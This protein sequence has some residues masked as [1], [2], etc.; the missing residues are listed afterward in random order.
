MGKV[1][2]AATSD[3][4][5]AVARNSLRTRL[6]T[7]ASF[8]GDQ[9]RVKISRRSEARNRPGTVSTNGMEASTRPL[10][11]SQATITRLR[12]HRSTRTPAAGAKKKPGMSRAERTRL[13]APSGEDPPIRAAAAVTATKPIQSPSE[14]TTWASQ[15]RKNERDPNSRSS[16]AVSAA[17]PGARPFTG[18]VGT[19]TV[20][21]LAV[22][23]PSAS[24]PDGDVSATSPK[25]RGPAW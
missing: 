12:S 4:E 24:E 10:P 22:S 7:D 6:G 8:A 21:W 11:T 18:S 23:S 19:S 13:I 1:P 5:L 15:R 20:G 17:G 14:D 2:Y 3:K 9:S 16:E 25:A